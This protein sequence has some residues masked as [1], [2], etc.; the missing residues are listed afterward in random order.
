[1]KTRVIKLGRGKAVEK[2]IKEAEEVLR[3]GGLVGVPTETVYGIAANAADS[4]AMKKLRKLKER[5][6][7]EPFTVLIGEKEQASEYAG[8]LSWPGTMLA[9]RG[10]PGP[11]T[12]VFHVGKGHPAGRKKLG[13]EQAT[14]Y[15]VHG[16]ERNCIN[17]VDASPALF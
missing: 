1:M 13:A 3:A 11:L 2:A 4:T 6:K 15:V 8:E 17:G 16:G 5:G 9:E 7:N 10:W 12:L 14:K